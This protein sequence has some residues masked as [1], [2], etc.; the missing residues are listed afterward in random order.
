M[1]Q[2][3]DAV[4]WAAGAIPFSKEGRDGYQEPQAWASAHHVCRGDNLDLRPPCGMHS[5]LLVNPVPQVT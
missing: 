4:G 3:A 1:G 5:I 2:H